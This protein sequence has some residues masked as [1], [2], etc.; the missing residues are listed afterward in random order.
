MRVI[1]FSGV[2]PAICK[3]TKAMIDGTIRSSDRPCGMW[4][5]RNDFEAWKI[6]ARDQIIA[7]LKGRPDL[8][9]PVKKQLAA[10]L[11][12]VN[13]LQE[14]VLRLGAQ[15]EK[16]AQIHFWTECQMLWDPKTD[17]PKLPTVEDIEKESEKE[18]KLKPIMIGLGL[19]VVL[20]AIVAMRK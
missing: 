6:A 18:D 5:T 4:C 3:P 10:Y 7:A 14:D 1:T 2:D 15:C 17:P 16:L 9:D 13:S 12:E 11:Q 19:G 20:L 8:T